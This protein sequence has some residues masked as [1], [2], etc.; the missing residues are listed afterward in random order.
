M[1]IEKLKQSY[2]WD[3]SKGDYSKNYVSYE[4]SVQ[5]KK[6]LRKLLLT[7]IYVILLIAVVLLLFLKFID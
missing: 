3:P 1:D 6:Y 7:S 2:K 4:R 5:R